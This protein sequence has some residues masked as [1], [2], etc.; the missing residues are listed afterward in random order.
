MVLC[1][2]IPDPAIRGSLSSICSASNALRGCAGV[3]GKRARVGSRTGMRQ[4]CG[5]IPDAVAATP[6]QNIRRRI[7]NHEGTFDTTPNRHYY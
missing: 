7:P 6:A 4:H 2:T 5:D 3:V 1:A